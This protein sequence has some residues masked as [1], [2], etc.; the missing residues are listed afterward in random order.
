[1]TTFI[2]IIGLVINAAVAHIIGN[3]AKDRKIGYNT[4][5]LLSF[6]LSP[7]LGILIVLASPMN[8]GETAKAPQ[9]KEVQFSENGLSKENLIVIG[10]GIV[11]V[12]CL[13]LLVHLDLL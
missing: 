13:F 3:V 10:I 7:L 5:F 1:M 11:S 2:I 8:T 9:V 6:L 12:I 4:A